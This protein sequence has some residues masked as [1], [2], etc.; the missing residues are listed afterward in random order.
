MGSLSGWR[1][2]APKGPR[3]Q[4]WAKAR[5]ALARRLRRRPLRGRPVRGQTDVREARAPCDSRSLMAWGRFCAREISTQGRPEG[6]PPEAVRAIGRR[7]TPVS[8]RAIGRR[9]T[10]VSRR[11]IGRRKTPVF[12]RAMPRILDLKFPSRPAPPSHQ[13]RHPTGVSYVLGQ[14]TFARSPPG[15]AHGAEPDG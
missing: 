11:A 4:G 14:D 7:K 2:G 13:W 8:R 15:A 3:S 1:R 10:P 6:P 9:K 12:R 5:R